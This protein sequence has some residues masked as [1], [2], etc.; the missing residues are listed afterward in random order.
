MLPTPEGPQITRPRKLSQAEQGLRN[1]AI[2][3]LR[4]FINGEIA[5]D[6]KDKSEVMAWSPSCGLHTP[7]SG[8]GPQIHRAPSTDSDLPPTDTQCDNN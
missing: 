4:N 6:G 1:S 3:F 5:L 8:A 7:H 2:E